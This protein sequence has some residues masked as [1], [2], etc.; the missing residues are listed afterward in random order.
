MKNTAYKRNVPPDGIYPWV[1]PMI[2]LYGIHTRAHHITLN[3][4]AI[5][6]PFFTNFCFFLH[7]FFQNLKIACKKTKKS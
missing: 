5:G 7:R 6:L 2:L 4:T 3:F 1:I